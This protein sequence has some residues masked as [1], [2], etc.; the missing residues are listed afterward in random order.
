MGGPR[1]GASKD[2]AG[3]DKPIR[4]RP[5]KLSLVL[6]R[7]DAAKADVETENATFVK[8]FANFH[9]FDPLDNVVVA[10]GDT[11]EFTI[12]N[13][14]GNAQHRMDGPKSGYVTLE[15]GTH[16]DVDTGDLQIEGRPSEFAGNLIPEGKLTDPISIVPWPNH[17]AVSGFE[18]PPVVLCLA[19]ETTAQEKR[20]VNAVAALA[21]R[22][23]YELPD[24]LRLTDVP[25]WSQTDSEP[26]CRNG[27][28]SL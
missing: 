26:H 22:L 23:K 8:R 14:T 4:H 7:L 6:H 10:D 3:A 27:Q 18:A 21:K 9:Q 5:E 25:R 12:T 17:V 1:G 11:W 19:A 24:R 28:R 13:L 16:V 15:D 2:E 20:A